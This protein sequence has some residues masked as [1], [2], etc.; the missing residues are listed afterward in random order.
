MNEEER[1]D[2]LMTELRDGYN[3]PPET[4]REEMWSAIQQRLATSGEKVVSMES[5]RMARSWSVRRTFQWSA[6][7]AA[8]V[9]LGLGIGRWTAPGEIPGPDETGAHPTVAHSPDTDPM[10]VASLEHLVRTESLLTLARADA[11]TGRLQPELGRWARQ[12]LSQTRLLMDAR[13]DRNPAMETLLQDLELVLVQ[14]VTAAN[15]G[16]DDPSQVQTEMNLALDGLEDNEVLSRIRAFVP[17]GPR[18]L[19][20]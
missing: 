4:P 10:E 14:L 20:T 8:L 6:A 12:L 7:A 18:H 13:K 1:L 16:E 2:E 11:R 17:A 3:R 15:T 5:A 9:V 19:G